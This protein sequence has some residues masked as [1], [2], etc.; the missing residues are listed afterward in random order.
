MSLWLTLIG[1]FLLIINSPNVN[2]KSSKVDCK[3]AALTKSCSCS[4]EDQNSLMQMICNSYLPDSSSKLPE[5]AAA[6]VSVKKA[7]NKWPTISK[8]FQKTVVFDL[9]VNKIDSIGDLSNLLAVQ[10]MNLSINSITKINPDI[11]KLLDLFL[12]DLS[13][14]Q[15]EV[16]KIED[17]VCETTSNKLNKNTNYLFS[18][19]QYL[20]LI[21][22][23]IKQI[24][25]L[26]LIFVAMPL[27]TELELAGNEISSINVNDL[28]VNSYNVLAKVKSVIDQY[29]NEDY[30]IQGISSTTQFY[31]GFTQNLIQSVYFNFEA[32][33]NGVTSVI[34]ISDNLL[35]KFGS[36]DLV[37]NPINCDCHLFKDFDFIVNG[38]FGDS[39]YYS[40]FTET[41]LVQTE[42]ANPNDNNAALNMFY[43]VFNQETVENTFCSADPT[44]S[45]ASTASTTSTIIEIITTNPP[46]E[47]SSISTDSTSTSTQGSSLFGSDSSLSDKVDTILS[48]FNAAHSNYDLFS[49]NKLVLFFALNLV[50][51]LL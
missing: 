39:Q 20:F 4:Y 26:D 9:S 38:P 32:I 33:Y 1:S 12:L 18:N 24:L 43:S 50:L 7:Y 15:I 41:L 42:C 25:R 10:Y 23:K 37:M 2:C 44:S 49:M 51:I 3:D 36:I 47:Q 46:I 5:I 8:T 16:L 34:G 22:N 19:L 40:N 45:R 29:N 48:L 17:F 30:F 28:S 14:N 21:G 31:F 35:I 13:Y 27:L 11:C 6:M